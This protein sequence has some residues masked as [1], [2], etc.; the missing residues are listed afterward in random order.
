MFTDKLFRC[1][2]SN[3]SIY[4]K[5]YKIIHTQEFFEIYFLASGTAL[6]ANFAITSFQ[7]GMPL[8]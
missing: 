4:A 7:K 1:K 8:F 3:T 5:L 6:N 2:Q